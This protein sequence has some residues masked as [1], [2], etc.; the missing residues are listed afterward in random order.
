MSEITI[1]KEVYDRL[2]KSAHDA[3]CLKSL[4]DERYRRFGCISYEEIRVL[5]SLYCAD[6]SECV[7]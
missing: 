1:T 7:R 3:D 2:V 4:L 6:E 5:Y